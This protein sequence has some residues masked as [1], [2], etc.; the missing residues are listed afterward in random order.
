M[1]Y[2]LPAKLSAKQAAAQRREQQRFEHNRQMRA[3][4]ASDGKPRRPAKAAPTAAH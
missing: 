1:Q 2:Q 4:P 3:T